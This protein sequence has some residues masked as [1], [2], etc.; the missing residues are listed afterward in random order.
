MKKDKSEKAKKEREKPLKKE[1]KERALPTSEPKEKKPAKTTKAKK[2]P[3][4]Y[5]KKKKEMIFQSIESLQ[6]V[7]NVVNE[8][9]FALNDKS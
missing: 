9:A 4:T 6:Q 2:E 5:V 8:A 1:K 7:V 3:D